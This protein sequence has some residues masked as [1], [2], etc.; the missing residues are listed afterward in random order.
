MNKTT[1]ALIALLLFAV[2]L[3]TPQGK[4][5]IMSYYEKIK[6]L[7]AGEEGLSLEVYQ[8]SAG[9]WTIG[10]GHLIQPGEIY[11][12]SG[13]IKLITLEEADA[14]FATDTAIAEN[15]V[16]QHVFVNL[17][18]NQR[19]AIVSLV[20]NIG[21][22]NFS[23]STLLKKLNAGDFPTAADEFDKWIHTTVNGVLMVD[24]GLVNRR[25]REKAI[26]LA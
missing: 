14:L 25:A 18:D 12:P 24:N 11:Y 10:Y 6:S 15:C 23:T 2:A 9:K 26:F 7:I 21:C 20:Y 19:A 3:T 4:L 8:D 1:I 13:D 17:T 5:I 16:S 22:G